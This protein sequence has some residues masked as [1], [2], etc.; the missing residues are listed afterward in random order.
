MSIYEVCLYII[1]IVKLIVLFL[2]IRNRFYPTDTST[3]RLL[4][5]Q[6]TFTVLMS[7][8]IIYLFHPFSQNPIMIDRETKLFLS[9]FAILTLIH[10]LS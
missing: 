9:V 2:F 5:A 8:L 10:T 3:H 7:L 4:L 1:F 6:N